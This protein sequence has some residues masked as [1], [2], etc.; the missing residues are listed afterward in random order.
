MYFSRV[1]K[2]YLPA[3]A[4]L[5]KKSYPDELTVGLEE[6]ERE[7]EENGLFRCSIAGFRKG[8]LVCYVTAYEIDRENPDFRTFYI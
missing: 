4:E 7:Y 8:E 2:Q 3:I 5:E 6:F 1:Y